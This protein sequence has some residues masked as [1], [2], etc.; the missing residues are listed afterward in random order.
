MKRLLY[1]L[2]QLWSRRHPTKK[3]ID[4][5]LVKSILILRYDAIGDM[6]VTIPM[7]DY[8]REL[9]PEARIDVVTS[10]S[11]DQIL[12]ATSAY[13]CRHVFDRTLGGLV[14]VKK[15]VRKGGYDLVFSLVINKTTLAGFLANI[16]GGRVSTTV[17]FEHANRRD[18][19]QT[20]FNIQV[21]QER[22]RDVMTVMQLNLVGHVF[23]QSPDPLRFPLH[24]TLSADELAFARRSMSWMSGLRIVL[25]LSAGNSY[26]MWSEERNEECIRGLLQSGQPLTISLIGH[27]GRRAMADRLAELFPDVVRVIP[28]GT[29]LQTAA[30]LTECDLLVTP[31][32]SMVHAA[33]AL[34]TPVFVLFTRRA[35][36]INEWMPHGVPFDYV[37]TEGQEDLESIDP[38]VAVD[39][40]VQFCAR[41]RRDHV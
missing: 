18:L 26:R 22:G 38:L 11:N 23:G 10:P 16:L 32:T 20:W 34:K 24:L 30:C 19:Y 15:S 1:K 41:L 36:F 29:F 5:T 17:S 9:C 28:P 6:I 35:T 25:N 21:P 27:G 7:I 40:L 12:N 33:S 39:G 2:L 14:R 37:I 13:S 3:S 4:P 8:L 31:D